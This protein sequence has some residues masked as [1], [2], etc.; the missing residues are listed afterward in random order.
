[1]AGKV[2]PSVLKEPKPAKAQPFF[3][4]AEEDTFDDNE[5]PEAVPAK[6]AAKAAGASNKRART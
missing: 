5:A 3:A 6:R 2:K 1:M 4:G